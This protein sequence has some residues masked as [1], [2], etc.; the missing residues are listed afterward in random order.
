MDVTSRNRRHPSSDPEEFHNPVLSQAVTEGLITDPNGVYVDATLGGGG[1]AAAILEVLGADGRLIGIDRDPE[2]VEETTSKSIVGRDPRLVVLAGNF[3][4]LKSLLRDINVDLVHGILLDLGVSSHQIDTAERGFSHRQSGPLDMRMGPE[5]ELTAATILN[6]W[7]EAEIARILKIFGE[8]PD[9]R[10]LARAIIGAR[11]L[12]S[13]SDLSDVVREQTPAR[14]EIKSLSRV[15]QAVRIVVNDEMRALEMVLEAAA[16]ILLAGGRLV[17]ISYHSLEDRRVKR[18]MRYGNFAGRPIR[19]AMGVL[20][21]PL[22]PLVRRPVVPTA[23]EISRNPR[24][25]SARLR[26]AERTTD[27]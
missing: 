18:F 22:R 16:D 24:A 4:D 15:F 19:D 1:H 23:E 10:R 17:V 2:A 7:S 20:E 25:R 14:Y 11:P 21:S 6:E 13:T 3:R 5:S 9:A 27:R 12:R 26:I 8:Q